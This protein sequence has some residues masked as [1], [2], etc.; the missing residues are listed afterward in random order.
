MELRMVSA[1][2][3]TTSVSILARNMPSPKSAAI[4]KPIALIGSERLS[5]KR[6]ASYVG[7]V[8]KRAFAISVVGSKVPYA[9]ER[10]LESVFAKPVSSSAGSLAKFASAVE[11][12][13]NAL[14]VP[15]DE[16][17]SEVRELR[18]RS[19][20]FGPLP[21]KSPMKF[22]MPCSAPLTRRPGIISISLRLGNKPNGVATFA[23]S[24][25]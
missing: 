2:V 8:V 16:S 5:R 17:I 13:G 24:V 20:G 7:R 4:G 11:R 21:V 14:V 18:E 10:S 3:A 25:E 6:L 12:S 1:A 15:D 19:T 23:A 22:S 9:V